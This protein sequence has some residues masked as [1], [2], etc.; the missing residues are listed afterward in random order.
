MCSLSSR[1]RV[2]CVVLFFVSVKIGPSEIEL[3]VPGV[4]LFGPLIEISLGL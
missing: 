2:P 3:V 1:S 4:D